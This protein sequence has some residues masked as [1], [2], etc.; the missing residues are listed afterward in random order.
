MTENCCGIPTTKV[1]F[2]INGNEIGINVVGSNQISIALSNTGPQG[3]PGPS[4]G[5][6]TTITYINGAVE[7]V[8]AASGFTFVFVKNTT[9]ASTINLPAIPATS[10]VVI[11]ID[12]NYGADNY[13]ITVSGNGNN[14]NDPNGVDSEYIIGQGAGSASFIWNGSQWSIF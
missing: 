11:I 1:L 10:Q 14:I 3:P 8:P 13:P 5:Q 7:T 12:G 6:T 2:S 4:G 9:L